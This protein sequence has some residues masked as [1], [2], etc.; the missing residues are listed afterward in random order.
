MATKKPTKRQSMLA[1]LDHINAT[2]ELRRKKCLAE[3][4][5]KSLMRAPQSPQR[6]AAAMSRHYPRLSVMVI[7]Q[8]GDVVLQAAPGPARN[9]GDVDP[10]DLVACTLAENALKEAAYPSLSD[11]QSYATGFSD[12]AP[13]YENMKELRAEN[14]RLKDRQPRNVPPMLMMPGGFGMG[15]GW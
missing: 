11:V 2:L 12:A 15:G 6:L 1:R 14:A 10:T 3:F 9:F 4:L 5:D 13:D 8:N 7:H